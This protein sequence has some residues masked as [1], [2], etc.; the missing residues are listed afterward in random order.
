LNE[1]ARFD[2]FH[3]LEV[4]F[5]PKHQQ[6]LPFQ[7]QPKNQHITGLTIQAA[8]DHRSIV[9]DATEHPQ[10]LHHWDI[11]FAK[12]SGRKLGSM[13]DTPER[14]GEPSEST[15]EL[16]QASSE[17]RTEPTEVTNEPPTESAPASTIR[18][19]PPAKPPKRFQ[20]LSSPNRLNRVA[21]LV[22]IVAGSVFVAAVIFGTG[23]LVGAHSGGDG[24]AF[25]RSGHERS[26]SAMVESPRGDAP[27]GEIWLVP[28]GG[29]PSGPSQH[30]DP[31]S[32]AGPVLGS[33]I[34]ALS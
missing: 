3:G 28:S 32:Y 22:A 10:R 30:G 27:A 31:G 1:R 5:A 17:P 11:T 13:T 2:R 6:I 9:A 19:Q 16:P 14:P 24:E 26:E 4:A 23:V 18:K 8:C 21:A 15:T 25:E 34:L 12:D 29:G 7:D 20:W 33:A